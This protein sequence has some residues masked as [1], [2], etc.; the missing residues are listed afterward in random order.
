[1]L[2]QGQSLRAVSQRLGHRDPAVTL[3]VYAHCLPGDDGVLAEGLER[4]IG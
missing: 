2:S 1:L 3:R 4:L